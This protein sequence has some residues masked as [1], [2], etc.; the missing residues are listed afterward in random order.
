MNFLTLM[1]LYDICS[2]EFLFPLKKSSC[3]KRFHIYYAICTWLIDSKCLQEER[4]KERFI[5]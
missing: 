1:S 4:I 5:F 2:V 3:L